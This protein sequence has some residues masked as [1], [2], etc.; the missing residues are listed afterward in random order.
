ML[1]APARSLRK[2]LKGQLSFLTNNLI[3]TPPKNKSYRAA[4]AKDQLDDLMQTLQNLKRLL[5]NAAKCADYADDFAATVVRQN[6][7]EV[8]AVLS[9]FNKGATEINLAFAVRPS[10]GCVCVHVRV[11]VRACVS[12]CL[13]V[14]PVAKFG[15][16]APMRSPPMTYLCSCALQA[17]RN[18]VHCSRRTL[19]T[20]TQ[21]QTHLFDC[22]LSGVRRDCLR[23]EPDRGEEQVLYRDQESCTDGTCT[24]KHPQ[25]TTFIHTKEHTIWHV[26]R[27]LLGSPLQVLA[28]KSLMRTIIQNTGD[29]P[30]ENVL[31]Q[32]TLSRLRCAVAEQT[33][34][35][36]EPGATAAVLWDITADVRPYLSCMHILYV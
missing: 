5:A 13:R 17:V 24:H 16:R 18:P 2:A 22:A 1:A 4:K 19:D 32:L 12:A 23:E 20:S 34:A 7:I 25:H 26:T 28:D 29:A 3:T 30:M 6:F 15:F 31:L 35:K 11:H 33:V 14:C 36:V 8:A 10:L 21:T 27:I 9:A